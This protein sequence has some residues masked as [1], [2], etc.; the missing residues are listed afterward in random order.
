MQQHKTMHDR[1]VRFSERMETVADRH[2]DLASE[3]PTVHKAI[4]QKKGVTIDPAFRHRRQ[5]RKAADRAHE[6]RALSVF[7]EQRAETAIHAGS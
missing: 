4:V 1:L 7:H 5:A 3:S 2:L 6:A